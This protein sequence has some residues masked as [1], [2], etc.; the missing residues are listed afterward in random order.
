MIAANQ[1]HF[2]KRRSNCSEPLCYASSRPP[3]RLAMQPAEQRKWPVV[4]MTV[5]HIELVGAAGDCSIITICGAIVSRIDASNRNARGHPA[6]SLARVTE[7]AA[8]K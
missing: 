3:Q 6:A 5:H 2:K 1:R 4:Q 7:V 8:C